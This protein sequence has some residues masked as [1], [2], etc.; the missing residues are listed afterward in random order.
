MKILIKNINTALAENVCSK[1]IISKIHI[2]LIRRSGQVI[3]IRLVILFEKVQIIDEAT[4]K[5]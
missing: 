4:H 5:F 3:N 1:N 2:Y